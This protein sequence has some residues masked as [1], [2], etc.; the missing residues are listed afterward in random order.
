MLNEKGSLPDKSLSVEHLCEM[1]DIVN[2]MD[3]EASKVN[4]VVKKYSRAEINTL[5][6][7]QNTLL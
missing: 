4:C 5:D 3:V 1:K 2:S 7:S 6:D